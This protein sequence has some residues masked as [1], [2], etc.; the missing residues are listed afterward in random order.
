MFQLA[1]LP[2]FGQVVVVGVVLKRPAGRAVDVPEVGGRHRMTARADKGAPVVFIH[3]NAAADHL[4]NVAHGKGDVVQAALAVRQLKQEQIVMATARATA[5]KHRTVDVAV[6]HLEAKHLAVELF[7]RRQLLD[8]E[9]HV[10]HVNRLGAIVD[11]AWRVDTAGIAPLVNRLDIQLHRHL[12]ADLYAQG[13][14]VRIAT[15]Q[16]VARFTK[17]GLFLKLRAQRVELGLSG[18]CPGHPAQRISCFKR[19]RQIGAVDGV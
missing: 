8:E 17:T 19:W 6:R 4:V 14:A 11:R 16:R 9:H 2:V 10:A 1:R 18:D 7:Y 13:H 15:L 3:R 5:Q 12:M